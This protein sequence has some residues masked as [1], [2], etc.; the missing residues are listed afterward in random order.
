MLLIVWKCNCTALF[1]IHYIM[2]PTLGYTRLSEEYGHMCTRSAIPSNLS[3][4][5]TA[6]AE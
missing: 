6:V 1:A 5:H 2:A 4:I 3:C